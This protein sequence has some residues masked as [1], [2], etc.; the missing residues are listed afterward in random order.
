MRKTLTIFMLLLAAGW[1]LAGCESDSTA[2]NDDLAP[3]EDSDV[4][5]QAGYMATAMVE[6]A[7]LALEYTPAGKADAVD[8]LYTY[9]FA[10]G[11]P[12][13]GVVALSFRTGGANGTP[14][15]YDVADYA[16][17][18][19]VEEAPVTVELIEGGVPWNL[20]F[21]LESALDQAAGTAVVGGS[22]TLE[23]G[24]YAASWTCEGLA[25]S[26]SGDWPT[27][28][29]LTFTNEGITATVTF[30]GDSTAAVTV[31]DTTWTLNLTNGTLID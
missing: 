14:C 28:G 18:W 22:G 20:V 25:V 15:G 30:D 23:V 9:I 6:V 4:A 16:Q 19:A 26:E 3:L 24:Q 12:V 2:P 5:S 27:A 1:L 11:D 21:V 31:G 13:Q 29:T 10:P 7:P 8:G 17:A